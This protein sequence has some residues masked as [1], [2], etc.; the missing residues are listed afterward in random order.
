VL[1]VVA[2]KVMSRIGLGHPG[3][4]FCAYVVRTPL[5]PSVLTS[6]LAFCLLYIVTWMSQVPRFLGMIQTDVDPASQG[7]ER[8]HV[9]SPT[10]RS[11]LWEQRQGAAYKNVAPDS[12]NIRASSSVRNLSYASASISSKQF[13]CRVHSISNSAAGAPNR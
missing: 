5:P 9:V 13:S 3:M 10:Y 4:N 7:S 12:V 11:R 8:T 1:S 6:P 2:S